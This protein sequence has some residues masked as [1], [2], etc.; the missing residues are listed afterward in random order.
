MRD[1]SCG[2]Q[3]IDSEL[4]NELSM[5]SPVL[6]FSICLVLLWLGAPAFAQQRPDAGSLQQQFDR[7]FMQAPEPV[8]T[9][10]APGVRP[11]VE[12]PRDGPRVLVRGI[13]FSG[14]TLLADE[15][16]A[17]EVRSAIGATL[18]LAE[19][20]EL[21]ARI[22]ATYR[23][24]GWIARVLLPPQD[25]TD[26]RIMFLIVES[27]LSEVV[28]EGDPPN[29]LDFARVRDRLLAGQKV[30]EV[31]DTR[32]IDR[33][34]LLADDLP[35]VKVQG[36]YLPGAQAA[37]TRYV[38]RVS[39][40]PV[41]NGDLWFDN[42]GSRSTGA[43]R[44]GVVIG[45]DSP[46]GLG[47]QW[48]LIA[49]SSRGADFARLSASF[50]IGLRG[51]RAG[52]NGSLLQ[53]EVVAPD[54]AALSLSGRAGTM[55]LDF[56]YPI[57]RSSGE[58]I[59]G[60]LLFEEKSFLNEAAFGTV[61]DYSSQTAQAALNWNRVDQIGLGGSFYGQIG[62]SSIRLLDIRSGSQSDLQPITT[63]ARYMLGR[64]Q[65]LGSALT[66]HASLSGQ[67]SDHA[68][69][70]SEKFSL[71]GVG[72][73]RAYPSGEGTGSLGNLVKFELRWRH[74]S[75]VGISAFVDAG[76]VSNPG[77]DSGPTLKGAGLA[78]SSES[79]RG[80]YFSLVLGRRLGSNSNP[81]DAG[82]DQDGSLVLNRLWFTAGLRL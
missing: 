30:G 25:V 12:V 77:N 41:W 37:E 79:H 14:N 59:F 71:G 13:R 44:A 33:A 73:V 68:L 66:L 16:L 22:A 56:S 75:Q 34:T 81:T 4:P 63:R 20:R 69:D 52:I 67:W 17:D 21:A 6:H 24:Q 76:R 40:E 45:L 62:L 74:S 70:S 18:T 78:L 9:V 8:F 3:C 19:L 80:A 28:L 57:L 61:S 47:D 55:G 42:H 31:L 35:G 58:N 43:A 72:G 36:A 53:Y 11:S 48:G 5:W 49:S 32:E 51:L 60:V 23:R 7:G 38:V 50:P 26:G 29:R 39:D 10:P 1:R 15:R 82:T 64:N 2:P 54:L 27:V 65:T 46:L